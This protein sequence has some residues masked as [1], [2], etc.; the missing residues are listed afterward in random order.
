MVNFSA[1]ASLLTTSNVFRAVIE[2]DMMNGYDDSSALMLRLYSML[3]SSLIPEL[4]LI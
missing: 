2:L 3:Q 4:I 1:A